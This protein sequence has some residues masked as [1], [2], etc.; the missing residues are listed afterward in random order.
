MLGEQFEKIGLW[1]LHLLMPLLS[2]PVE[3]V[4]CLLPIM[5]GDEQRIQVDSRFVELEFVLVGDD[6]EGREDLR[7]AEL[8]GYTFEIFQEVDGGK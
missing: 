4:E 2:K 7:L 1:F 5:D 8:L 6:C 3:L